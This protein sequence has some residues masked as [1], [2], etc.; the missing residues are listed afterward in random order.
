LSRL[1]SLYNISIYTGQRPAD[2]KL[3][4]V[5]PIPTE[6]NKSDVRFLRPISH[7][8]IVSKVLEKH[9]HQ[10][11]MDQLLVSRNVL[12]PLSPHWSHTCNKTVCENWRESSELHFSRLC[13]FGIPNTCIC[14]LVEWAELHILW[15]IQL[16]EVKLQSSSLDLLSQ[17]G[18]TFL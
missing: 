14:D 8:P 13:F 6:P 3:F 10:L 16:G 9:L 18:H 11:L 7:F 4:S 2:W 5:V 1:A 15:G 12:S 17:T